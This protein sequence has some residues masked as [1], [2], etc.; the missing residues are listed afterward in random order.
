MKK[1]QVCAILP[2]GIRF[3][4]QKDCSACCQLSGG[5]VYLTDSEA[6]AVAAY[7]DTSYDEFLHYFTREIDG[8]LA[9]QDGEDDACVFLENGSC[10]IYE[11]RP[12]Q[13]RMFPFWPENLKDAQ[14]WQGV[15]EICPGIGKGRRYSVEEIEDML[16]TQ[17]KSDE[18]DS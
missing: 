2:N 9:L 18:S 15:M 5:Y 14:S 12:L 3:A 6:R 11:V 1:I 16:R 4:C 8:V 13:C 17:I 10:L 7:L